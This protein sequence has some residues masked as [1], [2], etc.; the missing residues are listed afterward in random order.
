MDNCCI[1]CNKSCGSYKKC[2]ECNKIN[3]KNDN[4]LCGEIYDSKNGKYPKCYKCIMNSKKDICGCGVKYNSKNGKYPKCYK[5]LT[6][7]NKKG[8]NKSDKSETEELLNLLQ[9]E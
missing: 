2:Y 3:N 1:I 8:S 6:V 9:L 5:C 4:C 7:K